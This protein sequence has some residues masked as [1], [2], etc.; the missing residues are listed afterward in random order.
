[1]YPWIHATMHTIFQYSI[2]SFNVTLQKYKIQNRKD[3]LD[4]TPDRHNT[5][6]LFAYF[7][8]DEVLRLKIEPFLIS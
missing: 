6:N 1:M 4:F 5:I 7:Q 3:Y 2:Y 8:R